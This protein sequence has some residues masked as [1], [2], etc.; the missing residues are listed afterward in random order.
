[1][2][3][4]LQRLP[5]FRTFE[6]FARDLDEGDSGSSPLAVLFSLVEI[7]QTLSRPLDVS[8]LLGVVQE[9]LEILQ[10]LRRQLNINLNELNSLAEPLNNLLQTL[11][12]PLNIDVSGLTERLPG[13][14]DSIQTALPDLLTL[15]E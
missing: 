9:L 14:L 8:T 13:T 10:R 4:L 3:G 6:Q 1:M 15:I 7:G 11:G 5:D 12:E 2:D